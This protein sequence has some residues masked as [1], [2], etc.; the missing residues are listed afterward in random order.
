MLGA[1]HGF[2]LDENLA[3][4]APLTLVLP[5]YTTSTTGPTFTNAQLL[6]AGATSLV[7]YGVFVFVQT[8]RHRDYFLPADA[9]DTGEHAAP[10]SARVALVSMALLLVCLV[11]VVGLAKTLAPVIESGV[12]A[13]SAPVASASRRAASLSIVT[14]TPFTR[15]SPTR[16][17]TQRTASSSVST[18][19]HG[20]IVACFVSTFQ[21]RLALLI[22]PATSTTVA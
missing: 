2:G 18:T 1:A 11:S 9:S 10:P 6:F 22:A 20:T 14:P 5:T 19:P 3:A 16:R 15:V 8:V 12:R 17:S 13:A 21:M 4:L 7:L